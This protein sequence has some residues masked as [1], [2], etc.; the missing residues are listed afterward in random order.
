MHN[1][2]IP[3]PVRFDHN[4][5]EFAFRSGTRI[6]YINIDLAAIVERFCLE[7]TLA[8][9]RP[10]FR[11]GLPH[12]ALAREALIAQVEIARLLRATI[13]DLERRAKGGKR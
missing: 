8:D 6:A 12:R 3:A 7:V 9:G 1:A 2:V 5:G 13:T 11:R 4:R 10:P